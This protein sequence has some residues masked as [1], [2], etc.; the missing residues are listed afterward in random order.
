MI[1]SGVDGLVHIFL[2]RGV[3]LIAGLSDGFRTVTLEA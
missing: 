1:W 3:G 2:A